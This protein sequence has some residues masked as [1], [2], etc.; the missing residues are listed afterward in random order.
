[1]P[2]INLPKKIALSS[3]IPFSQKKARYHK[4]ITFLRAIGYEWDGLFARASWLSAST[5]GHP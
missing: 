5:E 3:R 1:L 2:E 4:N